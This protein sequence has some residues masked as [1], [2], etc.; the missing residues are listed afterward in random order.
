[1]LKAQ[2]LKLLSRVAPALVAG[3][4][5]AMPLGGCEKSESES[6][7]DKVKDAADDAADA[8]GDAADDAGDA[9]DDAVDD[10][11]DAVDDATDEP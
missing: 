7:A 5:L 9:V 6:A 2:H 4:L 10:A 1:M 8:V 11:A 3:A